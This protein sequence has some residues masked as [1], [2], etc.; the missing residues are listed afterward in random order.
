MGK[1][2]KIKYLKHKYLLTVR[3][4]SAENHAEP[5]PPESPIGKRNKWTLTSMEQSE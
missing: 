5:T 1:T 3:L 2:T 4:S